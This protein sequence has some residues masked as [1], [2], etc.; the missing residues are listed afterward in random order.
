MNAITIDRLK[1]LYPNSDFTMMPISEELREAISDEAKFKKYLEKQNKKP[2]LVTVETT[3]IVMAKD[4]KDADRQ[5]Q[6][7]AREEEPNIV[8]SK[9]LKSMDE[10]PSEWNECLPYNDKTDRTINQ[11][12]NNETV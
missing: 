4:E 7:Y 5:G 3:L 12:L 1:Q 8:S 2:Y 6:Y 11:I 10:V 9:L